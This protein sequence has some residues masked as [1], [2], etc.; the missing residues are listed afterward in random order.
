VLQSLHLCKQLALNLSETVLGLEVW[1]EPLSDGDKQSQFPRGAIVPH[2]FIERLIHLRPN[3][4]CS[5]VGCPQ[6]ATLPAHDIA[7][8]DVL[9]TE[10]QL[11]QG[12]TIARCLAVSL[13]LG[14]NQRCIVMVDE[15]VQCCIR[16]GLDCSDE[17]DADPD[18]PDLTNG[19]MV[20]MPRLK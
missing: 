12:A 6:V 2:Q 11:I 17:Y 14:R 1:F 4:H 8:I 7:T 19:L 15:C 20:V 16:A 18:R 9:G 3:V 10:V 5:H 13:A